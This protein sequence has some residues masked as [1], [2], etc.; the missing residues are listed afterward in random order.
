MLTADLLLA[1]RRGKRLTPRY[2]PTA[3]PGAEAARARAA[4]V[5]G[6]FEGHLG[7]PRGELDEALAALTAGRPDLKVDRGLAKL[8]EDRATFRGLPHEEACAL[9]L[10]VFQAAARARREGRF[11]REAVLA[12]VADEPGPAGAARVLEQLYGDHKANEVLEALEPIGPAA[13]VDRYN[14]GLAQAALLRALELDATVKDPGPRRL[15]QLV[16]QV[17]FLGLLHEARRDEAGALRL[18]LDGPLSL[19]EATPRY[20][21]RMA[22]FL[23]ALVRCEEWRLE[24]TVQLGPRRQRLELVLGPEDGLVSDGADLGMWL[25]PAVEALRARFPAV[26]PGW[27]VDEDVELLDLGGE[28]VVPD[29]RFVHEASGWVGYLEVLGYWRR[30]AIARRLELLAR[31]EA[32]NLVLAVDRGLQLGEQGA[33]GLGPAVVP[34]RELPSARKVKQALE[35]LRTG[36]E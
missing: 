5:I 17:R 2:L 4:E 3:G 21:V 18:R 20:G 27:R 36:R 35:A 16:R 1:T 23:P 19:F 8:L 11:E 30:R 12:E 32:K 33:R 14:L 13:L 10:R 26:A 22:G 34:F 6:L 24:A 31:H 25:P 29:L 28:A 9:R 7:R 15:R